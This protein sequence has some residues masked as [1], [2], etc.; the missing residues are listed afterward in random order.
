MQKIVVL[1]PKLIHE[2][3]H[4]FTR[5]PRPPQYA[6]VQLYPRVARGSVLIGLK[7]PFQ[8]G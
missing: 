1:N 6:D 8:V 3:R 4:I 5:A 7:L 2:L